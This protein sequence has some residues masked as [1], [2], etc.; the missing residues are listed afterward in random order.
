[1]GYFLSHRQRAGARY[2]NAVCHKGRSEADRRGLRRR[3]FADMRAHAR[4]SQRFFIKK[5]HGRSMLRIHFLNV[6]HG[7][8]TII[9]HPSGR[10][11]MIDI[12]NSQDYDSESFQE[13]L[14]DERNRAG[15]YSGLASYSFARTNALQAGGL[16][17]TGLNIPFAATT[18]R[19]PGS[20][21]CGRS[22][23]RCG[24]SRTDR[25]HRV[26]EAELPRAELV[27]IHIDASRPRPHA[28]A[29]TAS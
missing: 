1:M 21:F 14:K 17:G 26:Y 5:E 23:H 25:S 18:Y 8:C 7:D 19:R 11:T 4:N 29:K 16:L 10:L 6:G 12:N 27:S 15:A 9:S 24:S 28:G 3:H 2:T 22:G 20:I 13:L